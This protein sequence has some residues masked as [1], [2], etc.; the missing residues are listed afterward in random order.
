MEAAYRIVARVPHD[1]AAID[2]ETVEAEIDESWTGDEVLWLWKSL[3]FLVTPMSVSRS[4]AKKA[5]QEIGAP[6]NDGTMKEA[7]SQILR[8]YAEAHKRAD[9]LTHPAIAATGQGI[10]ALLDDA[11][12]GRAANPRASAR[13]PDVAQGD[14]AATG[15]ANGLFAMPCKKRFSEII[16]ITLADQTE[17]RDLKNDKGQRLGVC[18]KFAWMTGDKA[19]D[20]YTPIDV[21]NYAR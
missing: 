21:Q 11:L 17:E 13:D 15:S 20:E 16:E 7:R 8:G 3:H 6:Q 2:A 1:C 10:L 9:Y 12:V 19:L 4:L 14:L 18:K 5:L